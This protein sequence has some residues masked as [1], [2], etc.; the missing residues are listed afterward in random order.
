MATYDFAIFGSTPFATMLAGLLATVHGKKTC[1]I[2]DPTAGF[3]LAR[4]FDL[5]VGPITRPE[6]WALLSRTVPD[7]LRLLPKSSGR[8]LV[9]RLD[10][11]F[12]ATSAPGAE[13][14]GHIRHLATGYGVDAERIAVDNGGAACRIRDAALLD[15]QAFEAAA[16]A[17]LDAAKV[18]RHSRSSV[19]ITLRRDGSG[20]LEGNAGADEFE[21]A[22]LAD[23]AAILALIPRPDIETALIVDAATCVL[24]EP[25]KALGAPLMLHID[26]GVVVQQRRNGPISALAPGAADDAL[27]RIRSALHGV[28]AV[29]RAGQVTFHRLVPEDGAPMAGSLKASRSTLLAGFGEQ[30][31][32]FAPS[33]ARMIANVSTPDEE[34]WF[35]ERPANRGRVRPA[36]AEFMFAPPS[37]DLAA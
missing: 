12:S 37:P 4:G 16:P 8:A 14:L 25:V 36:V 32:F 30:R 2:S 21:Q 18:V 29:R 19:R 28:G 1:L 20:K 22:V 17:W 23:D 26:S 31:L 34:R 13:L 10:P 15:R 27:V 24:T 3:R 33:V 35:A 7:T 11:V 9:Q 6:T 5:S